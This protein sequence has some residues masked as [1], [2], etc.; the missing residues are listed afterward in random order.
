VYDVS[1]FQQ[2]SQARDIGVINSHKIEPLQAQQYFSNHRLPKREPTKAEIINKA[3]SG[4]Q[5]NG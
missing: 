2:E 4:T 3:V 1:E 5:A